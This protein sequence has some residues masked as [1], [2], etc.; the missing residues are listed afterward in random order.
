MEQWNAWFDRFAEQGK[1]KGA[2]PLESDG[3]IVSGKNGQKVSDGPFAESKEAIGGYFR[4]QVNNPDEALQIAKECPLLEYGLK[5]EV[6]PVAKMCPTFR[7]I[8]EPLA[9]AKV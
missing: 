6:R 2:E 1:I 5:V 4:L 3:K 7:S 9:H 8:V